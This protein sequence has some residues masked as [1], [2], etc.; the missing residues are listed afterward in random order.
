MSTDLGFHG[1]ID[2]GSLC[3]QAQP[4]EYVVILSVPM[5]HGSCVIEHGVL[6]PQ[7]LQQT[8]GMGP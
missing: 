4:S 3:R 2:P 1:A 5:S 6:N 7:Q 8:T